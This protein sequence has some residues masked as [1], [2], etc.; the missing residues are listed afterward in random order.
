MTK[1]IKS[2]KDTEAQK[3]KSASKKS[4]KSWMSVAKNAQKPVGDR[5]TALAE[6]TLALCVNDDN[7]Q[8]ILK[9]IRDENEPIEVR[10][11]ALQT[12][13]AASFSVVT[14][15]SCRN[16]YIATLREV[17]KDKDL[18]LR[19]RALGI[20]ARENDGFAQQELLEGLEHPEKALV[21]PEKAL[22]LLSYDIHTEAYPIAHKIIKNPPNTSAKREAL[23]LLA[24]DATAAPTFE[25]ILRDKNET[26]EIRQISA[27]A[28]HA[29][30]PEKLQEN[31]R[32]ILLDKSETEE[33]Q[34]LSLTALT[35]FGDAQKVSDDKPLLKRVSHLSGN[36]SEQIKQRADQFL[37]KYSDK[38]AE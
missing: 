38:N 11:A 3:P 10:L 22:Q 19:Q 24:G 2:A 32:E 15:E 27:S 8:A 25:E 18:E 34:G 21:P 20:L 9:V 1:K 35:Q 4:T 16:D 36:A 5:I 29:V 13:Q 37:D 31:A 33:I 26:Y 17:A 23:R 30:D 14:F 12:L 6:L 7:L 28:L